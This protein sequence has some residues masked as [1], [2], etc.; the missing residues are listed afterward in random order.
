ML[1]QH[2]E[3]K[4]CLLFGSAVKGRLEPSS[5]IDIAVA[6]NRLLKG[7]EKLEIITNLSAALPKEVDFVDLN[8]VSDYI[9]QQALSQGEI[10]KLLETCC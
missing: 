8:S 9:L 6:A 5:D 7:E 1:K 3:I 10:E 2:P 4:L